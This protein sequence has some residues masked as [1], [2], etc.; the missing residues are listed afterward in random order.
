MNERDAAAAMT[1]NQTAFQFVVAA[2]R[3]LLG[4]LFLSAALPKIADPAG[5]SLAVYNYHILPAWL[6]NIAAI[7]LPWVELAAGMC[8]VLGVWVPGGA[9]IV[10]GLLFVFA[11]AL[12]FNL[13]RGLDIACG[14]FSTDPGAARITWWYLLR[15]TSLLAAALVVLFAD[16]GLLSLRWAVQRLRKQ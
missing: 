1:R 2:L 5:F 7:C 11:S 6:V 16:Q 15:D 3:I 10:A 13:A 9:L 8:L 12:G 14:C 4:L